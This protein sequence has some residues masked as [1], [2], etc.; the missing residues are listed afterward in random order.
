MN[1]YGIRGK[2]SMDVISLNILLEYLYKRFVVTFLLCL[3]G[4]FIKESTVTGKISFTKILSSTIFSSVLICVLMDYVEVPFSLFAAITIL[5]G[6]WS[7]SLIKLFLNL[8][9]IQSLGKTLI[10]NISGP[11]AKVLERMAEEA[12]NIEEKLEREAKRNA[13]KEKEEKEKDDDSLK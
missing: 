8:K 6:M 9:F 12:E 2:D 3:V 7:S 4:A 13:E 1:N 11:A 5:V 10:K